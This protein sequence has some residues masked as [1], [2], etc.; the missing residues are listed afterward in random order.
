M[1]TSTRDILNALADCLPNTAVQVETTG[2]CDRVWLPK[3]P[4]ADYALY[5]ETHEGGGGLMIGAV[6][7][8]APPGVFFWHLPLEYPPKDEQEAVHVLVGEARRLILNKSRILQSLGFLL[9]RLRCEVEEG[10]EWTRVGGTIASTR[11]F[12]LPPLA[13]RRATW[14]YDSAPLASADMTRGVMTVFSGGL[15]YPE[16]DRGADRLRLVGCAAL[17]VFALVLREA[18]CGRARLW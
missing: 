18:M 2:D 15:D 11:L 1:N 10:G 7:T 17:V 9:C 16:P 3:P 4:A 6:P 12:F 13:F 8:G 14:T 5:I